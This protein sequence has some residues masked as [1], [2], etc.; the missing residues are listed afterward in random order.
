MIGFLP[1]LIIGIGDMTG[2]YQLHCGVIVLMA[3]F[4]INELDEE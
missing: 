4:L 1:I 2:M 3:V